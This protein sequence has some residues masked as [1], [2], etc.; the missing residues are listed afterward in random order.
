MSRAPRQVRDIKR[1]KTGPGS[2]GTPNQRANSVNT[3]TQ[4][5]A[6]DAAAES[7][8]YRAQGH[9]REVNFYQ[10]C[11]RRLPVGGGISADLKGG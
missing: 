9:R 3:V 6:I 5:Q 4:G 1:S 10:E 11:Q 2:L 7:Q 8:S